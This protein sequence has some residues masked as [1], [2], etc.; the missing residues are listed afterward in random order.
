MAHILERQIFFKM[1]SFKKVGDRQVRTYRTDAV[2]IPIKFAH[3]IAAHLRTSRKKD[4]RL[5]LQEKQGFA[6]HIEKAKRKK[7]E[8]Q[9]KNKELSATEAEREA[10]EWAAKGTKYSVE[11][12]WRAMQRKGE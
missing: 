7:E 3:Q 8:L 1:V 2:E 12:V 5:T 4:R 6:W 11:T 9:A 10:A